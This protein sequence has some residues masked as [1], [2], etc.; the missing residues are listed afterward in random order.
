MLYCLTKPQTL[1]TIPLQHSSSA[2]RWEVRR[3]RNEVD[4]SRLPAS[5]A[6]ALRAFFTFERV[7]PED[8]LFLVA[9]SAS[10][11]PSAVADLTLVEA[12]V[13]EKPFRQ[14]VDRLAAKGWLA[15][16]S[17]IVVA[18]G[19]VAKGRRPARRSLRLCDCSNAVEA[20]PSD[21]SRTIRSPTN[22]TP[23]WHSPF[24]PRGFPF[25]SENLYEAL[26]DGSWSLAAFC[27][28]YPFVMAWYWMAGGL[29]FHAFRERN[30]PAPDS[31]PS[32]P[33]YPM[34]SIMIPCH[35]EENQADETFGALAE[36]DYPNFEII[37]IN[38]GSRDR[39]AEILDWYVNRF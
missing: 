25:A 3:R 14:L 11:A 34:V 32:L 9:P 23:L 17:A 16:I 10:E 33:S 30:E 29:L 5:D 6:L 37:A 12:P 18:F 4:L 24:P 8:R 36:V 15:R 22:P 35:N 31:P 39:T 38:D 21:G 20:W 13:D 1:A 27:F 7:R 19:F 28:G 26:R 2:S